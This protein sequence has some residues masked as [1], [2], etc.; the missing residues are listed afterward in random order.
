MRANLETSSQPHRLQ[1]A[2]YSWPN[3]SNMAATQ[4]VQQAD[5]LIFPEWLFTAH[6]SE[7]SPY[8]ECHNDYGV[9]VKG[10]QIVAI[11]PSEEIK[12]LW[13]S[14]NSETHPGKILLPGFV[15]THCH[16]AMTLLRGI[17]N[18]LP[19]MEWLEGHIWPAEGAHV[20]EQFVY[21]GTL[22]AAAEMIR[23]GTTCFNDMYFFPEATLKA[24][25]QAGMRTSAGIIAIDFPSA[26][27]Q[28]PREY[29][30]KGLD[31]LSRYKDKPNAKMMLAPH[32]PYTVGDELFTEIAALS[33]EH[34]L[35]IHVHLHETAFEVASAVEQ[36]GKRPFQRLLDL[37]VLNSKTLAVHMTQLTDDEIQQCGDL[38]VNVAHC[39]ESNLKLASGFSPSTALTRAGANICIGTDG[40]ASNNDLDMLSELRS[41]SLLAK[42]QSQDATAINAAQ[43]LQMAT[44]NGAKAIGWE[45]ETGSLHL[46]KSA[47]MQLID[48]NRIE[49]QPCYDPVAQVVYSTS[50]DQ[51]TDVWCRGEALMRDRTLK[52]LNEAELLATA[53]AWHEKI[54][55]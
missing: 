4:A 5:L 14:D 32:A 6:P 37:G 55:A 3:L 7:N 22:L 42:A 53:N 26:Y 11:A 18:D 10:G 15:N 2:I 20:N 24:G 43:T 9:A 29:L 38:G 45:N 30:D 47:D 25:L 21:D 41:A 23:C 17:A 39:P 48:L 19:L 49:T 51:I 16:S 50:R 34:G 36:S 35:G 33:A 31:T 1:A 44:Y 13:Q 46:G 52:T 27:A 54:R 40:A 28:N 8:G 12:A